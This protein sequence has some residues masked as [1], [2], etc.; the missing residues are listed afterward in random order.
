MTDVVFYQLGN[1]AGVSSY[2]HRVVLALGHRNKYRGTETIVVTGPELFL[3]L[4]AEEAL[5]M[6]QTMVAKA[7]EIL[8]TKA[9]EI[10]PPATGGRSPVVGH[11]I[12]QSPPAA[13][14]TKPKK[15]PT[16]DAHVDAQRLLFLKDNNDKD[17][18]SKD[19][20]HVFSDKAR[21]N[22]DLKMICKTLVGSAPRMPI[23]RAKIK[24]HIEV[25]VWS[26]R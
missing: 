3:E 11:H 7:T 12:H 24:N 14:T 19:L 21:T 22:R 4:S 10:A 15:Q 5:A 1:K 23:S 8:R 16:A 17:R 9:A 2:G 20:E 13:T 26:K 18:F 25:H 6:G